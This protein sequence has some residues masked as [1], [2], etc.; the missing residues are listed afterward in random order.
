MDVKQKLQSQVCKKC[1]VTTLFQAEASLENRD[2]FRFLQTKTIDA[3][4][5]DTKGG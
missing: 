2:Y 3:R 5:Q 4:T 1:R